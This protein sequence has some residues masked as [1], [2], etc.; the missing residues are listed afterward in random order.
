[1]YFWKIE[2]A[3]FVIIKRLRMRFTFSGLGDVF[4]F[5]LYIYVM[6]LYITCRYNKKNKLNYFIG[7]NVCS[8]HL[9]H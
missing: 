9:K 6:K 3:F 7:K 5:V 4:Y 1:M 8:I 2:P